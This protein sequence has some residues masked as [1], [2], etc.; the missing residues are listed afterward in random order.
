[1]FYVYLM[2]S[3]NF[4]KQIYIGYTQNLKNRLKEHD[5]GEGKHTS[6]YRP[7]KLCAY[8]A[9]DNKNKALAFENYLKSGSGKAFSKKRFW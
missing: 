5:S 2:K 6:R 8:M 4:P 7:W 3:I 1:M 9:F